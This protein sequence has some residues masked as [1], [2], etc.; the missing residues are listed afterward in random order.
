LVCCIALEAKVFVKNRMKGGLT[1]R[2]I[3]K[4]ICLVKAFCDARQQRPPVVF[5][6]VQGVV[7]VVH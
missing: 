7:K 6:G 1:Y 2:R 3:D 4:D 5:I